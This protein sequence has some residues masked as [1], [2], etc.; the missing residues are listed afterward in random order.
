MQSKIT[1]VAIDW[2]LIDT[3]DEDPADWTFQNV[4]DTDSAN[5]PHTEERPISIVNRK[6]VNAKFMSVK[7]Y[8]YL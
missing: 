4:S 3:G 7:K 2:S 5:E 6:I 1:H 8:D